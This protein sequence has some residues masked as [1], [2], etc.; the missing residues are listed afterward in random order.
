MVAEDWLNFLLY[1]AR[2]LFATIYT[3]PE[4]K[5][6]L[7]LWNLLAEAVEDCLLFTISQ[8]A[9]SRIRD[10]FVQFVHLYER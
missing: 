6:Y 2:P 3:T 4:S 10:R 8:S 5:P 7:E 9:I 1:A